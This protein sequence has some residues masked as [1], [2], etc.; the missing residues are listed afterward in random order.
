MGISKIVM[1]IVSIS[2]SILVFIAVIYGLYQLGLHSYSYGYRI[3]AEPPVSEVDKRE[4]LVEITDSMDTSAIGRILEAKGL[5]RD[6]WLFVV[7]LKLS[8][9]NNKLVPGAYTLSP[10]MTVQEMF[11]IMSGEQDAEESAEEE[12]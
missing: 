7:Q 5:I 12:K 4:Y 11:R 2:F 1:R 8:E 3:F 6:K 9:Y 10:S